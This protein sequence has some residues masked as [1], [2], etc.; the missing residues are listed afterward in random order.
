MAKKQYTVDRQGKTTVEIM[1]GNR[2]KLEWNELGTFDNVYDALKKHPNAKA[3]RDKTWYHD[4]C[5]GCW[6]QF[7]L[8]RHPFFLCRPCVEKLPDNLRVAIMNSESFEGDMIRRQALEF[9]AAPDPTDTRLTRPPK[10][11][12][13]SCKCKVPLPELQETMAQ[14]Y[15]V[16]GKRYDAS[17]KRCGN[18]I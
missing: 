9:L 2:D 8:D 12:D 13:T 16:A 14:A 7:A 11:R 1:L 3:K 17:C 6:Q 18:Q 15:G 5:A 4:H 10:Q